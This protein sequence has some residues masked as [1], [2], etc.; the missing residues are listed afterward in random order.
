MIRV[1]LPGDAEWLK[2]GVH[3]GFCGLAV[4][5]LVYNAAAWLTRRERHLLVNVAFYA[6]VTAVEQTQLRRHWRR[7]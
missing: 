6:A 3:V 1:L 4:A 2:A 5:C 7:I